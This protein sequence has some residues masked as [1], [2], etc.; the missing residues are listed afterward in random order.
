MSQPPGP[1]Y[2]S[3]M[4]RSWG[5]FTSRVD[6]NQ[7]TEQ[8]RAA[9]EEMIRTGWFDRYAST[10]ERTK[11]REDFQN[12]MRYGFKD[13]TYKV[14]WDVWRSEYKD[15]NYPPGSFDPRPTDPK[16]IPVAPDPNKPNWMTNEQWERELERQRERDRRELER[17]MRKSDTRIGEPMR[18]EDHPFYNPN[19]EPSPWEREPEKVWRPKLGFPWVK[20]VEKPRKRETPAQEWL[21]KERRKEYYERERER[22]KDSE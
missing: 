16:D 8:E 6:A 12:G 17:Q 20:R 10:Y 13:R 18:K 9:A 7:P 5:L 3:D 15:R 1:T 21:R 2:E 14:N 22:N 4:P 19:P 11:A